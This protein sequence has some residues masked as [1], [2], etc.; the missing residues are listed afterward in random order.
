M[1]FT[2]KTQSNRG[3]G[4]L[5]YGEPS[6][7]KSSFATRYP[8]P[9]FL[10]AEDGLLAEHNGIAREKIDDWETTRKFLQWIEESKHGYESLVID[11][12]DR[13]E[14][15]ASSQ[16]LIEGGTKTS[17]DDR[18]FGYGKY[19]NILSDIWRPILGH[20]DRIQAKGIHVACLAHGAVQKFDDPQI[21]EYSRFAPKMNLV[22]WGPIVEWADDVIF[23]TFDKGIR[24]DDNG[25][26]H[27]TFDGSRVAYASKTEGVEAKSRHGLPAKFPFDRDAFSFYW[28]FV[29][30]GATE[31]KNAILAE[32]EARGDEDLKARVLGAVEKAGGN[33]SLLAAIEKQL[34]KG[35]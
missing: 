31:V 13:L 20:L 29:N 15:Y 21:G 6:I 23:A 19:K 3:K 16:I 26:L 5:L 30:R 25:K 1:S 28:G 34:K 32:L 10:A 22:T 24:K 33:V 7:G 14:L 11:T 9:V 17:V 8:K 12:L 18:K 35:K 27:A 4:L 2:P